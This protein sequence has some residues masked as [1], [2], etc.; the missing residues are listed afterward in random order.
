[1]TGPTG[2]TGPA[3]PPGP[4]AGSNTQVIYNNAGSAAGSANLTFNGTT[5][6]ATGLTVTNTITGSISGNAATATTAVNVTGTVAVANGGTGST[7]ASGARTNLGATTVG[8][9]LFTL[10]NPSAVTFPRF[11]AD[12]TVS[13][14]DAA[15]FR[16][17]IGAGTGSG[18]VTSVGVSGGTTGLT[19]TNSPV[20]TSGT[21]TLAGTLIVANGGTGSTTA[22]GARTN[23]GATTVG[24]NLFTLT[25]PSA[26]TF[27]RFNADNTVSAL[28]AATFRSAIGAGTGSGTVTSVAT[29]TGLTG[30]TITS[31]GTISIT[32]PVLRNVSTGY[33]SGGQVFVSS[34]TPTASAQ[35]DIWFQI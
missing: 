30:G 31:S 27:P 35:G 33:T 4:I 28:D 2:P 8:A 7:T 23:L 19:A 14:L 12:N 29:G 16:T 1:L 15:T 26:V 10:T 9:N 34:T 20:T 21:I 13:A 3:G 6:S 17:A 25:N 32:N 11:N 18:T 24:A 5:L 22:S